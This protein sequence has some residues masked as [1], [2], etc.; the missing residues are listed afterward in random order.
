MAHE[1]FED[2]ATAALMNERFVNVKVDRE[3]RP[4]V[5]AIY[6]TAT[7]AMTG[8]GG[9][10]MTVFA[11]PDGHPF[12]TGTYFPRAQFQRLLLAISQAWEQDREGVIKQGAHVV[13]TLTEHSGLPRGPLPTAV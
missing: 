1:S 11:T 6:M 10:P 4:D 9:W 3:E 13:R 5:D 2:E 7:Q 12:Y 8:Q